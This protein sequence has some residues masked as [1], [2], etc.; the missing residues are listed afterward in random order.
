MTALD[1]AKVMGNHFIAVG[2]HNDREIRYSGS[3]N[4]LEGSWYGAKSEVVEVI[5]AKDKHSA[6]IIYVK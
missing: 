1:L 2:R 4:K 5:P 6:T 3:A